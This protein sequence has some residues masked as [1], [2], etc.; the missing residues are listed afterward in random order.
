MRT[1]PQG[2]VIVLVDE[3]YGFQYHLWKTGMT[4]AQLEAFWAAIPEMAAHFFDPT[5]TLPGTWETAQSGDDLDA[6]RESKDSGE[7]YFAHIHW[8]DD[9]WLNCPDG[10]VIHH[11][12]YKDE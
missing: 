8:E 10:R 3:E 7:F 5:K 1:D 12:G 4:G 11:A 9:S 6:W 2:K